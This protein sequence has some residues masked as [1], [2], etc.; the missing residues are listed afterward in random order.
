M[1]K[2]MVVFTVV[3]VVW[4]WWLSILQNDPALS[5][6]ATWNFDMTD[7]KTGVATAILIAMLGWVLHLIHVMKARSEALSITVIVGLFFHTV[8]AMCLLATVLKSRVA[9]DH[10]LVWF[11]ALMVF[12][13]WRTLVG[14]YFWTQYKVAERGAGGGQKSY[15]PSDCTVVVAT[16]GPGK[17]LELFVR[18]IEAILANKPRRV[19][20]STPEPSIADIVRPFVLKIQSDFQA[21]TA[22]PH[23]IPE[24]TTDTEIICTGEAYRMD[25]RTQTAHAISLVDTPIM[26]MAD[27]SVVWGPNFLEATLPAFE[28]DKVGFV[29][30]R[31]W[32]ERLPLPEHDSGLSA[33]QNFLT[34]YRAGFWNTIGALYLI[35]HNFEIRAS[36]AADGGVFC[37]S[38][39]TSLILSRIVKDEEFL[40]KFLNEYIWAFPSLGV[41]GVGP[42][43]ADDD[44]FITRWV[45]N[46]GMNVKIQYSEDATMTT[47]LGR[48]D[49]FKFL[50]QCIRWS[51]TTIRQNP[52][53]LF[54]DRTMW[55][56]WPLSVWMVYFPWMYN[57]ALFWD[58]LAVWTFTTT[59]FFRD[60]QVQYRWLG[61]LVFAIWMS[62][63]TKTAAW[64]MR[65]ENR[66]DFFWY[67]FPIPAYPLFAYSHS[68]IKV[69]T[70]AT[71]W[72]NDWGGR[73]QDENQREL[74][75]GK[76]R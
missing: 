18:M 3:M 41:E 39:R 6:D 55:W 27:D 75:V 60:S 57:A 64:F 45:V 61:A 26:V 15:S 66:S 51:R 21:R 37:V 38:G 22:E 24:S 48:V 65:Q 76:T 17:N 28:D 42:L 53:A 16:V 1:T 20:F 23:K 25:K 11:S 58:F 71:F 34:R 32:V 5:V 35:R 29:G 69:Y 8:P 43:K 12:R 74:D 73:T 54:V 47:Q 49:Q 46:R 33:R 7:W 59:A 9:K 68:I 36:N 31:K 72:V 13:Y 50:D 44:N 63:L 62:K 67:F 2:F 56:K 70:A 30:T 10:Q 4:L 14:V 40:A 52:I 19:I